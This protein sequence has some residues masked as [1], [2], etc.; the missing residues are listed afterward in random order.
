MHRI[1]RILSLAGVLSRRK[2]DE[3]ILSG[4]VTLNGLVIR[5]PGARGLWGVDDIRVDGSQIP[6]PTPRVSLMLNKPFGYLCAMKDPAGRPVVTDLLKDLPVRVYPVGRLD[7]DSL[8]LL[9]FTNDGDLSFRLT[10][11]GYHIPKTYKLTVDGDV[12]EQVLTALRKGIHLEDGFTGPAKA[13][14]ILKAGGRSIVRLTITQGRNRMV[15]RM[16]KALGHD[17]IHLIRTGFGG[18]ELGNL[19]VGEYRYLE[20]D[21]V[22]G[23][24][25]VVRLE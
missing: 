16:M 20:P 3:L 21:E 22:S 19:R 4:R 13:G 12:P 10:H 5:E 15:R 23:L 18:L 7:F 11:P 14:L 6:G 17:T 25:K 9:L 24:R 1:N 8:G 2:A